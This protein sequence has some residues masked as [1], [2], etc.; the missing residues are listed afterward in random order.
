[1]DVQLTNS[2]WPANHLVESL[3]QAEESWA[4]PPDSIC[5]ISAGPAAWAMPDSDQ[6][7]QTL[8]SWIG[9][10]GHCCTDWKTIF[11]W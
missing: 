9:G 7:H 8:L 4:L 2:D 5:I 6:Y 3:L 11:V 10:C 1:M